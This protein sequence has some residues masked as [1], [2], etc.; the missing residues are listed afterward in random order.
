MRSD[1]MLHLNFSFLLVLLEFSFATGALC[2]CLGLRTTIYLNFKLKHWSHADGGTNLQDRG[3][4]PRAA[5][6]FLGA[7][8]LF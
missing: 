1:L 7:K 6:K 2:F 3:G 4:L 8:V 5:H